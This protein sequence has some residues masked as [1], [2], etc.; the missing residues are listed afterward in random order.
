MAF[1]SH[2]GSKNSWMN[3]LQ[4]ENHIEMDDLELPMLGNP[5][6]PLPRVWS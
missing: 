3:G 1:H 2:G 6:P 4:L 5:Y